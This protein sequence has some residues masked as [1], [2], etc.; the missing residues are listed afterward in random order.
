MEWLNYHHLLYFWVVAREGGLAPAS[1]RLHLAQSTISGQ[2]RAFENRVGE[3]LFQRRGRRLALTE[4]GSLV[5]RY[6]DEIFGLGNE[7]QLA[8]KGT[9]VGRPQRLV[10]GIADVVPKLVAQR[11]LEPALRLPSPIRILCRED[12]PERLLA[13]LA[14]HDLDVVI[15]DAPV[16]R[17]IRVQAYNHLL[18]ECGIVFFAAPRLAPQLRRSFPESLHRAPLLLPS[19]NTMLR[20]SLEAWLSERGLHPDVV[21][22]FDDSALLG[23]FGQTGHGVFAAPEVIEK[24]VRR[25]YQVHV[26]GRL[27]DVRERFY[28]VS[29]ERRLKHPAV[30]AIS[31]AARAKLFQ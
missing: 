21:G 6:A 24:E 22:E 13:D 9:P 11:L 18:G 20:R 12:K 5:Y 19:E 27:P 31:E 29:V 16:P 17:S 8:L 2:I 26:V 10:V 15:A 30:Q 7:L 23:V 3:R 4:V 1:E 25:Q 28:A 14:V